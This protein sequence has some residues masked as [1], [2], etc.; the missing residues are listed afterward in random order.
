MPFRASYCKISRA[1]NFV[2]PDF[3]QKDLQRQK[4]GQNSSWKISGRPTKH[5]IESSIRHG[6]VDTYARPLIAA[7]GALPVTY[8]TMLYRLVT[9][10]T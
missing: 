2:K 1:R 4:I 8:F 3:Q 5:Q 9:M 7:G 10:R 6:Q